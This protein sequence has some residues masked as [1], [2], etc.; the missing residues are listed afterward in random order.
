MWEKK[1]RLLKLIKMINKN[2]TLIMYRNKNQLYNY[3]FSQKYHDERSIEIPSE[4]SGNFGLQVVIKENSSKIN[5]F[6]QAVTN[7]PD[8]L[9]NHK[10][11][12]GSSGMMYA[13]VNTD[14]IEKCYEEV[15][16]LNS[17]KITFSELESILFG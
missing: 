12:L 13:G 9:K 10:I 17:G 5:Y 15:K 4:F 3:L 6:V 8:S 14:L 7:L 2:K 1:E 11:S 16:R